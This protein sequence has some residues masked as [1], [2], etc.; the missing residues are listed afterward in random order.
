MTPSKYLLNI[1]LLAGTVI[2]IGR[3]IYGK[4]RRPLAD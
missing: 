1:V 4:G 2:F 3:W